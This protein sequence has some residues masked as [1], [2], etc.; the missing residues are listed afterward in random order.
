MALKNQFPQRLK[1]LREE[2]SLSIKTLAKELG[3]SDI[4]IG[5]WEKGLRT[6]N[7]DTLIL[8]ANYFNVS[9]DYLLGLK[10]Y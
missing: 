9:A 4:A 10:D 7:I 2:K 1:E 3:V 8:V 5:R 6:P